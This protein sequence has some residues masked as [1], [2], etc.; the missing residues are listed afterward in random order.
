[1]TKST[2]QMSQHIVLWLVIPLVLFACSSQPVVIQHYMLN[3]ASNVDKSRTAVSHD[4]SLIVIDN[5]ILPEYLRSRS[6]VMQ[7]DDG[8][9]SVATKHV[10]AQPMQADIGQLLANELAL[11]SHH[12]VVYKHSAMSPRQQQS[13]HL[14]LYIEHFLP[15][16]SGDVV[17]SG[18]WYSRSSTGEQSM[19]H[20]FHYS[21][22]LTAD[23][24]SHSV[25]QM[26]QLVL[27]L[28][29]DIAQHVTDTASSSEEK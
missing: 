26:R 20:S 11:K 15:V 25:A 3:Q 18:Y 22:P 12:P 29:N 19:P 16:S 9:L 17:M 8:T 13:Q 23:G 2:L 27:T 28:A 5:V 4:K 7:Q 10:W 21:R 1:M 6:L 24:Y 14:T